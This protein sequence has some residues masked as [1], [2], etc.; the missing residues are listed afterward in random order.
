[1]EENSCRPRILYLIYLSFN[2]EGRINTVQV[3]Q[4]LKEQ[5]TSRTISQKMLKGVLQD[6]IK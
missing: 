1:M 2:N 3:K 5:N 6:E 4:N